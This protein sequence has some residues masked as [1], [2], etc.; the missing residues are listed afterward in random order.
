MNVTLRQLRAFVLVGRLGNFTRAAQ[1][2]H[3]TQSA[4]SLLVRELEA[5]MNTRLLDRTTRAVSLTV[6]GSEFFAGAQRILGELES[7]I[8]GVDTLV[9]KERG[10][11][12]IAAPLVLSS[13]FLPPMLAAFKSLYPG[14]ELVLKDTLPMQ[15]LPQVRS[16]AADLGIGT[17]P[18]TE[19][20][21]ER[22]LLFK[23]AMVAVFPASHAFASMRRLTWGD[24]ASVPIL[25]L[26]SGSVFRDLAEAGFSSVGLSLH[27]AFEA[28]YAGSLIGLVAA[29]LGV[30]VLPGYATALTDKSR[31]RWRRLEKPLVEREVLLVRKLGSAAS[32]A[33]Q[34]FVDFLVSQNLQQKVAFKRRGASD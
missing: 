7:V 27:P 25:A 33:A 31:I 12:V 21:L 22:V 14:I 10:R 26:R 17:F 23:E 24:L 11:V 15:V 6:A 32:P 5:A 19:V 34:A 9:A 28:D 3:V 18:G 29:G 8:A 4:L 1:A 2:M 20:A 16:G 13:T 30:A